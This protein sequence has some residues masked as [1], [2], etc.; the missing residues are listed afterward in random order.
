MQEVKI[1]G[2]QTTKDFVI[3]RELTFALGDSVKTEDLDN[4]LEDNRKRIYNLRLFH[5][6]NY[7]YTCDAGQV[8]VTYQVQ[9]R[10]YLYPIPIFDF[11]DRN[12]NA[13]LEKK[14][15]RRIDYGF[16]LTRRNFRGRNE[17]VRLRLQHGFNRRIELSY[18]VPYLAGSRTFGYE[19]GVADYR[20]HTI[21]YN[22]LN[23]R[24][25]FFE[26]EKGMP[27]NRTSIAA[28]VVHRQSVQRQ[29]ALRLSYNHE[30]ISDTIVSLNPDY[31]NTNYT[32]RNYIRLDLT[33]V[34][35]QRNTFAY[36]LTGSYF[37]AG[38]GHAFFLKD[39][40]SG[41]TTV[42]AKYVKYMALPKKFYYT[43]GGEVQTRLGSDFAVTDNVALGYR[44]LVRGYELYVVGGQHFG[45]FKQGLSRELLN[46]KGIHLKFI[47]NPKLNTIPLA[48]YLNGF[49][50]AGYTIDNIYEA[51]NPLTNRLLIGGGIGLHVVTFYDIVLRGEYT[52]NRE[53]NRGL[54]LNMGYP[55]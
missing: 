17:D 21:N 51:R 25:H 30:E 41:F 3:L 11:A 22:I 20:S 27:I 32:N 29:S 19:V 54:Y 38:I 33:R 23:N 45:L 16:T 9:E 24:Q 48:L 13:W 39:T 14:D 50:D 53:G 4:L 31:F 34:I 28:A 35:N 52:A 42:R 8:I 46:I 12:F 36:P 10:A 6:V 44:S 7:S 15:L 49:T 37:D 47:R 55:F 26:Q 2:N 5:A 43:I 18:R 1:Q 40:G